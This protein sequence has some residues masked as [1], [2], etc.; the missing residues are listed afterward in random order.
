MSADQGQETGSAYSEQLDA[1]EQIDAEEEIAEIIFDADTG[2]EEASD[3]GRE[4]LKRVLL[5]FRPD[6][7]LPAD[8]PKSR[9]EYIRGELRKEGISCCE[10]LE[11]QRLIPHIDKDDV[12][13]LEAAGVP[14]FP[15][16]EKA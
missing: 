3:M 10:L 1:Q 9:L 11:L 13:L 15:G 8:H 5:R 16:E 4:I 2:E 6:L 7:F 14:E 12:E